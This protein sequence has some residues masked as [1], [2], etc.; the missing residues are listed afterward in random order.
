MLSEIPYWIFDDKFGSYDII[1]YEI[2]CELPHQ[3][4]PLLPQNSKYFNEVQMYV[5]VCLTLLSS[6][7]GY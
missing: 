6:T 2:F 4:S 1:D 5:W 7:N 3:V